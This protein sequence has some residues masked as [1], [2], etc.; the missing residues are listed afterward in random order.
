[1]RHPV[2]P[3]FPEALGAFREEQ[4]VQGGWQQPSRTSTDVTESLAAEAERGRAVVTVR[5]PSCFSARLSSGHLSSTWAR[6]GGA[7]STHC[8]GLMLDMT[9]MLMML[10]TLKRAAL[11][12]RS[13]TP[14]KQMLA[15]WISQWGILLQHCAVDGRPSFF[16]Y[17]SDRDCLAL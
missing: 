4:L 5:L 12:A 2:S 3:C 1:M 13:F 8:S 15:G 14:S 10:I 16:R 6:G 11:A 7:S 17:S 9:N